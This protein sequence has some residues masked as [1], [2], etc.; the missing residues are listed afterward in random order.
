MRFSRFSKNPT[1]M[2]F[3]AIFSLIN[4]QKYFAWLSF[5]SFPATMPIFSQI[6]DVK[7]PPMVHSLM[8]PLL[9]AEGPFHYDQQ[10]HIQQHRP[11]LW[12]LE[13]FA[14]LAFHLYDSFGR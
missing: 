14:I 1:L 13:T 11:F 7:V 8:H 9:S 5:R 12:Y 3:Y 6:G 4:V 2:Q 10:W